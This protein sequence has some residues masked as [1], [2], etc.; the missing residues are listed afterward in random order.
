MWYGDGKKKSNFSGDA[1]NVSI[2]ALTDLPE[3]LHHPVMVFKG[4]TNNSL[5]ILTMIKD[6]SGRSVMAVVQ[7]DEFDNYHKINRIAT[8][9]GKDNANYYVNRLKNGEALYINEK[10]VHDWALSAQVQSLGDV[11]LKVNSVNTII[12]KSESV[13]N[14]VKNSVTP[15]Q[16]AAY[17][18]AVKNGDMETA[19]KMVREVAGNSSPGEISAFYAPDQVTQIATILKPIVMA[20][21]PGAVDIARQWLEVNKVKLARSQ[22]AEYFLRLA[23]SMV[24]SEQSEIAR[25]RLEATANGDWL[26]E[27]LP[28]VMDFIGRVGHTTGA[29]SSPSITA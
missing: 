28:E 11:F 8:I 7:L 21:G 14:S 12:D 19:R 25:L 1:H 15:E 18:E 16:D 3:N 17:L 5:E 24:E 20:N 26:D 22:D 6:H 2:D 13:K 29:E 27:T 9:F 4:K 10:R 23:S